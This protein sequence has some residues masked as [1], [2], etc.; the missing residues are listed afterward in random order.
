LT[1]ALG[2][3]S[4]A[5]FTSASITAAL[6]RASTRNLTS[7]S[8]FFLHVGAQALDGAVL[9]AQRLG[10]RPRSTSGRFCCL[11]LLHGD[12]EVG[13]LA[14]DVLAVVVG[15]ETAAGRSWTRRPSC[16]ARPCRKSRASGL[17]RS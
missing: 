10:E 8:R 1:S 13:F 4:S 2:T 6:L 11:D 14:G 7:R 3:S 16:R 15:R 17:R 12:E 9:D 5:T